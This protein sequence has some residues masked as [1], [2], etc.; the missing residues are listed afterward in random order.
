MAITNYG[1]PAAFRAIDRFWFRARSNAR[2]CWFRLLYPGL[3]VGR[4][5]RIGPG[6]RFRVLNGAKLIIGDGTRID[7]NAEIH[8]DGYLSIGRDAYV[9]SGTIIVAA[10]KVAIGDDAL[11]AAYVAIRDQDHRTELG[12][13]P[14]RLQGLETSPILIGNNVWLGT[15]TTIL[16]GVMLGDN[17]VVGANSV[18]TRSVPSDTRVAGSPARPL[19]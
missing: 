13:R 6:V 8:S 17:C 2:L 3:S 1:L 11:I 19:S 5:V 16:K 12:D 14:F 15:G 4:D 7:A 18:V 9:G 10:E